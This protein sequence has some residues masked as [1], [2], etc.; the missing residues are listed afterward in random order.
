LK[1]L[2]SFG[3]GWNFFPSK[4]SLTFIDNHDNQRDGDTNI[5]TYKDGRLYKMATA[6]HLAWPYGVPRI[7]SSFNFTTREQGPPKDSQKNILPP[8]FDANGQCDNGW[9][10]EHRWQ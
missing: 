8:T 3:E 10:C 7:M 5:L 2:Q 9:V 1:W 6:F 4:Y